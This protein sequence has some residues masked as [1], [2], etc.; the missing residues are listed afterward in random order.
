MTIT[1]AGW[2]N[3]WY[4]KERL[5]WKEVYIMVIVGKSQ[6]VKMT[7]EDSGFT[8]KDAETVINAFLDS[9]L[10][11]IQN[12]EEVRLTGVATIG[13]KMRQARMGR[14]PRSGDVIQIPAKRV[15]YLKAG[16]ELKDAAENAIG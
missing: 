6:L 12:G 9:I 16:K 15:P 2:V 3:T 5:T 11:T 10:T 7:A 14:N 8:Q 13:S 4:K 1:L